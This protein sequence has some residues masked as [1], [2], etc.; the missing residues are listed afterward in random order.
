M[1]TTIST[2]ECSRIKLT[3]TVVN[4]YVVPALNVYVVPALPFKAVPQV[5]FS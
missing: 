4:V 1:A 2:A 3:L 5:Y